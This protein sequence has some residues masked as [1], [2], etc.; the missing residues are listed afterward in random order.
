MRENFD[1]KHRSSSMRQVK[2][3]KEVFD[4]MSS[5]AIIGWLMIIF[6]FSTAASSSGCRE[7]SS[8]NSCS[9]PP[10]QLYWKNH[11]T[12]MVLDNGIVQ[13]SLSNPAGDISAIK[14]NGIDVLEYR[15]KEDN[16]GYWDIVLHN[17]GQERLKTTQHS[18]IMENEDQV[19]VSFTQIWNGNIS[20]TP[21]SVDKRYI[22][23]RGSSRI[24]MYSIFERLQG[25]PNIV[26]DQIRIAFKLHMDRFKRMALSD[27][28][29]RRMPSADDVK[30]GHQLAYREAVLYNSSH[31]HHKIK[32]EVD[33]K[34]QYS[35]ENKE[36]RVHGWISEDS[37]VGFWVI[38]PSDEFLAGGPTKQ[39]LTSHVGPTSLSMFT[40]LHYT[41]TDLDTTFQGDAWKKVFGPVC[42]Y[43]NSVSPQH[44]HLLL[45]EDAKEQLLIEVEN[46]PYNFPQSKDFPY[47]DQR[48]TISGQLLV[49]DRYINER[50]MWAE[51]AYVGLADPGAVGS[52]QTQSKGY[53]FWT[54]A[55]KEGYFT[56]ENV[57]SGNYSLYAWVPGFVGNWKH[58]LNLVLL[59]GQKMELGV[60]VYEPPRNG[61]T[62]WEI[63]I[64]DRS[65]AE[66][67][68]PDAYP[69]LSNKLYNNKSSHKFRQYGLWD[70][71]TDLYPN[72]D[73]RYTV[74]LSNYS[75]DW[76]F[77]HVPRRIMNKGNETY[78]ATTWQII[79]ELEKLPEFGY[80]TLQIAL[81][82]ANEAELQVR[83]NDQKK[84]SRDQTTR[85]IGRDNAIARHG[86]HGL[87]RFY[88]FRVR[89]E[90]L[91][92]G[93][94]IIYLTQSRTNSPFS[95]IMYDYI[96]FEAPPL[97]P[98]SPN[99]VYT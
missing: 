49:H 78:E 18:V 46:W 92:R 21:L 52:W 72:H 25:W 87:Y 37:G 14:Y 76:F 26:I 42:I 90:M 86:I 62:L 8:M 73:L 89:K 83:V 32:Q 82:S 91:R 96:R 66:F 2:D 31:H 19:E 43:L 69:H 95:G 77:A 29:Q 33:D 61:P 6:L 50:L 59:P 9:S 35:I 3:Q 54:E 74:G 22:L 38:V 99:H 58:N 85:L 27:D 39:D 98:S 45:W 24:Y 60:L 30:K 28:R 81:A 71:Y 16:R 48:A 93:R 40:S 75:R 88:S 44:D 1:Y 68:V 80:Y 64:P 41:G 55:N 15:N 4:S 36:N 12:M 13:V 53:Q 67:F 34:Y 51:S 63:G 10:V 56:I 20:T 23:R 5:M 79:F 47:S 70:R 11:K 57:R 84:I 94:N 65:A 17:K 7:I 97:L